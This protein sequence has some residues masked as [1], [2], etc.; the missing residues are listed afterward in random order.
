MLA[1]SP[2]A[3]ALIRQRNLPVF[4]EP[5]Q[6][7]TTCCI[8]IQERPAVRWGKPRNATK[9]KE[10]PFDGIVIF[11]PHDLPENIPLTVDVRRFLGIQGL[12]L[13]GWRLI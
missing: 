3:L 1:V 8:T 5:P 2:A 13:Q 4:I 6:R 10:M 7:I 11:V 9:Y 12:T